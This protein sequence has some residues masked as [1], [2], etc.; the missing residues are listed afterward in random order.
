[1]FAVH[2]GGDTDKTNDKNMGEFISKHNS[3][4][5]GCRSATC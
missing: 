5:T 1:M 3:I 4:N 2:H